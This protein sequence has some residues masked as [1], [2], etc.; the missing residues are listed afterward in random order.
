MLWAFTGAIAFHTPPQTLGLP[1]GLGTVEMPAW[2]VRTGQWQQEK[3][4][5]VLSLGLGAPSLVSDPPTL[6]ELHTWFRK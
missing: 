6:P 3:V 2:R 1:E 4:S 5:D